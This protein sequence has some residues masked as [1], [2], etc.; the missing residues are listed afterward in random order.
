ML[1]CSADSPVYEEMVDTYEEIK[2]EILSLCTPKGVVAL[3]SI[4]AGLAAE[5]EKEAIFLLATIGPAIGERSTKAFNEG[6][7]VQGMMI[8]A[9]ADILLFS[10]EEDLQRESFPSR[11][12]RSCRK[13]YIL[14]ARDASGKQ[15]YGEYP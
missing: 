1:Q 9:M 5:T 13:P 14:Y 6:D 8:D 11:P 12:R 7:Y 3:G 15:A 4:P 10:M 2:D